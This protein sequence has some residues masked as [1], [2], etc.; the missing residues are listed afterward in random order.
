MG[1]GK[2]GEMQ[3][4]LAAAQGQCLVLW[5][6]LGRIRRFL[7]RFSAL[8]AAV[9]LMLPGRCFPL[10]LRSTKAPD[11]SSPIITPAPAASGHRWW[12]SPAKTSSWQ[13]YSHWAPVRSRL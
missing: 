2:P 1:G 10:S 11:I 6:R 8:Q 9:C 12:A 7:V 13:P 5:A 4:R 3:H